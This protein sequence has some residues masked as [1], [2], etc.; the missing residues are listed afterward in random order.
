M[1]SAILAPHFKQCVVNAQSAEHMINRHPVVVR[2]VGILL[3]MQ[4]KVSIQMII[5]IRAVDSRKF[6]LLLLHNQAADDA[7]QNLLMKY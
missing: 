2:S 7:T 5:W 3:T 1:E 4:V 6:D